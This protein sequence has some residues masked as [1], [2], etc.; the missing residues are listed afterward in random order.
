LPP[1]VF[2]G[3]PEALKSTPPTDDKY[4]VVNILPKKCGGLPV[5]VAACLIL[6]GCGSGA[7]DPNGTLESRPVRLDGEQVTLNVAQVE[8]GARE[9]LWTVASLGDE[10]SVARLT[11]KARDL[12]FSDDVQIGEPGIGVPYAQ[13]HGSFPVK[14]TQ[15]GSVR[16]DDPFTKTAD[17][18]VTVH[19]DHT[20][21]QNNPPVLMGIRHGKFDP[22]ANPVFRFKLDGE[23]SV[24]QI[25]H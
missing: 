21:F 4:M 15:M 5:C 7:F 12:Q 23:W 10:R 3:L 9:D 11:Q 24:D 25:V 8:C 14:V 22:S 2:K 1:R 18:K 17:A 16:D 6:A 20:C 19:I 13:I